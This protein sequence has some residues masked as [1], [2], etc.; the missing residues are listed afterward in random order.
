MSSKRLVRVVYLLSTLHKVQ[1]AFKAGGSLAGQLRAT[2]VTQI[3]LSDIPLIEIPTR[4]C[5]FSWLLT[6]FCAIHSPYS[7]RYQNL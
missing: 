6:T 1:S 3:K 4:T 5:G 7:R 2:D